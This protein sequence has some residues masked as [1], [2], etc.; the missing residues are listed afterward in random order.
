MGP[1]A[2]DR[3]VKAC[4]AKDPDERFQTVHDLKLQL[5]WI[6]EGESQGRATPVAVARGTRGRLAWVVVGVATAIAAFLAGSHAGRTATELPLR[7]FDKTVDNLRVNFVVHPIISPDA[8]KI[9]YISGNQ[10]SVWHQD[11]L[12][13]RELYRFLGGPGRLI[14]STQ[15]N[16]VFWSPDSQTIAFENDRKLWRVP[17]GGGPA[18]EI[19]SLPSGPIVS[20][21]WGTDESIVLAIWRSDMYGVSSRGG[22]AKP[23]GLLKPDHEVDFHAVSFLPGGRDLI[24]EVHPLA[25]RRSIEVLSRGKRKKIFEQ[26]GWKPSG[27]IYS[28]TGHLV[29]GRDEGAAGMWAVPFSLAKLE[30]TGEPFLIATKAGFPSIS[31]D[32]TL[33]YAIEAPAEMG[34]LVLVSR[35]GKVEAALAQPQPNLTSP[36]FSRDGKRIAFVSGATGGNIW[37]YDLDRGTLTRLPG[38]R[39]EVGSPAWLP[40]D[41][42]I[43]FG[44]SWSTGV[45][46]IVYADLPRI[47][48][49]RKAHCL[50]QRR[51]RGKHL[52]IR[53]GSGHSDKTAG[54]PTGSR[55]ARL[56]TWRQPDLIRRIL[57]YGSWRHRLRQGSGR[58]RRCSR[59]VHRWLAPSFCRGKLSGLHCSGK[60]WQAD[61]LSII[62]IFAPCMMSAVKAAL[63]I[64]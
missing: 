9:A 26:E 25:G 48:T 15:S 64:L 23:L 16:A 28:P 29:F 58:V 20:G 32:G 50:R 53:P 13:P 31:K 8:N 45:G 24:Y 17:I 21:A 7:K 35:E 1:P 40:G 44:E 54:G 52:D 39:Q 30:T 63:P 57:V 10:L 19:C 37:I 51:N 49:G 60:D 3:T 14:G 47:F 61:R 2:L 62:P 5:Q 56:A 34:Q 38:D 22:D 42:R 59:V 11:E 41:N 33:L 12:G 36:A 55:I 4:L 27:P 6:G 43:L 46:G 18:T